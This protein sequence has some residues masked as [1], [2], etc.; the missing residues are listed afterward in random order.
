M[1]KEVEQI[2]FTIRFLEEHR[3]AIEE[4]KRRLKK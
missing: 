2:E 3:K 4:K 1:L